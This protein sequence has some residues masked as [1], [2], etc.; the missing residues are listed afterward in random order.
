MAQTK[1]DI[2]D[3]ALIE[4]QQADVE[5]QSRKPFISKRW[6][7]VPTSYIYAASDVVAL[8]AP[9][10]WTPIHAKAIVTIATLSFVTIWTADLYRPRIQGLL[11]DELPPFLARILAVTGFVGTI[12]SL[13]HADDSIIG[14]LQATLEGILLAVAGRTLINVAIRSAR[15]K[16]WI[17]H[18]TLLVGS[19]SVTNRLAKALAS[20]PHYGLR[21]VA[22]LAECAAEQPSEVTSL[23][24]LGDVGQLCDAIEDTAAEVVLVAD[25]G[26]AEDQLAALARQALLR[27][28][29][30]FIVP[31]LHEVSRQSS[32]TENIGAIPVVRF[33]SSPRYGVP[34]KCKRIFDICV[35]SAALVLLLPV[36]LLCALA[37]RLD[38]GPGVL[39]R[40][41]RVGRDGVPFVLLKF[42]SLRPRNEEESSTTWSIHADLRLTR[43]GRLLRSTSL[44]ELPQLWNILRGDMAFVGP[45]PERPFFV[46]KFIAENPGYAFR[47]RVPSGLT[48]LAQVNGLRGDT[49]IAERSH[50]DNYYIENWS[51][52]LDIKVILRTVVEVL[53]RRGK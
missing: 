52:W 18:P 5:L 35:S 11:L 30:V 2:I 7:P 9:A 47:H 39:F 40:Q 41:V 21:P 8:S 49:S 10:L 14:V 16:Q 45:R 25:R 33:G 36:L 6:K 27:H 19:G 15:R 42:R 32:Y 17:S 31:R 51:L 12:S 38:G 46:E 20:S 3:L 22:Y 50:F 43:V 37:V 44:D 26:F 24:Y 48:G 13:R 23:P 34:W 4:S 53:G 1:Q 29:E 28:C